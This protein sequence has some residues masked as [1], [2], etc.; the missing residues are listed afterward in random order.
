M[1]KSEHDA[2]AAALPEPDGAH[3][4]APDS[5]VRGFSAPGPVPTDA[6]RRPEQVEPGSAQPQASA[7]GP[8]AP[9]PAPQA[10]QPP[11]W[12]MPAVADPTPPGQ[13]MAAD[14]ADPSDA[15]RKA[16][17]TISVRRAFGELGA[18]YAVAFGLGIVTAIALLT[19]PSLGADATVNGWAEALSEIFQYVMQGCVVIFAVGYFSLRRGVTLGKIFGRFT[20]PQPMVG[21]Y[22]NLGFAPGFNPGSAPAPQYP[23]GQPYMPPGAPQ[24]YP[25]ASQPPPWT[26]VA[27]QPGTVPGAN[28]AYQPDQHAAAFPQGGLPVGYPMAAGHGYGY[29]TA[30]PPQRGAGW[31]FAR[32]FF[33]SMTGLVGFLILVILYSHFS[34]Q[35][36]GA[37]NQ[38]T[39][40]W[41]LPV[42]LVTG[43]AAGFGEE[44]LITGMVVTTLEQTRLRDKVWIYY[45]VAL[46]LRIPFHLY[47]GW[48]ALGVI[49]FTMVNM[50]VYR[51]WRLLWPVVLAHAVYDMVQLFGSVAPAAIGSLLIIAMVLSTFVMAIVILGIELSDASARRRYRGLQAAQPEFVTNAPF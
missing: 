40:L 17:V 30:R 27:G 44:L 23:A 1:E 15:G 34:H 50:W 18:V 41:L 5:L 31:Q 42:G 9:Y 8:P 45:A 47:Y 19:Q 36:T 48:A 7:P 22:Y 6:V 13:P 20:R 26:G 51:R 46:C 39:S 3:I 29:F 33:V 21:A 11:Q 24:P 32:A 28:G 38:G 16:G 37:P 14:A 25:A 49:S 12:P 10:Q 43:L 35:S 4:P 2:D